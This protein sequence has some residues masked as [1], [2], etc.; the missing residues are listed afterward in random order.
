MNSEEDTIG[1]SLLKGDPKKAIVKLSI[2]MIVAMLLMSTYN[3][4]NA[5]WVAGLGSDALAAVGFITPLFMVL[6]GLG[7]GL[8]A[9]AT[10]VIS[11]RI[12]AGDRLGANAAAVQAILLSIGV[13]IL[14]SI[15]L[16]GLSK[17][18]MILF[19]AGDTTDLAV[20]FGNIVFAGTILILFTNIAYAIL[21]GEGDTKRTMYVMGAG[22]VVNI[23][24]DPIFIYSFHWGIAGAAW[25]MIVSLVLVTLVLLYWFFVKKDTYITL[26]KQVNIYNSQNVKDMLAI[27]LPAS[28]EFFLMAILSIF[29]N[30]I[31]VMVANTDAVAVYTAGWRVIMFAII[32]LVAISTSVVAVTGAAY[33]GRH[34]EKFPVIHNFSVILGI[35]IATIIGVLTWLFADQIAYIFA[36][37]AEGADLAPSIA[38]FL[39]TMCFFYPFVSP[40]IMSSSVFQGT[41]RGMSS[42]TLNVLREIVFMA[43]AAYILG[44]TLGY[45]EHGVWWG[46]VI[47]DI[48]GGLTGFIWVRIYIHRLMKFA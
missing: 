39:A 11:R 27:G 13:S 48:L 1:V 26:S 5:I 36:Y 47:G 18:L 24:L 46:I 4:V 44:V 37:S 33:G 22:S 29:I 41:G 10:A 43:S 14:I 42:L 28:C 21:R 2:P 6:I 12:G 30:S 19:G 35:V 20:E 32:P 8:G 38:A 45:G 15:I 7:T 34:Y 40:G 3:L 25:G 23:I 31:L 16:I 9:G 17:P